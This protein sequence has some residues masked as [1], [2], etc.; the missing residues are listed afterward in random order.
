MRKRRLKKFI[1]WVLLIISSALLI[2]VY[3]TLTAPGIILGD[4]FSHFWASGKLFTQQED[5]YQLDNIL[6]TLQGAGI[7]TTPQSHLGFQTLNPP[8]ALILLAPFGL[9]NYYLARLSWL[10]INIGLVLIVTRQIWK[11]YQPSGNKTWVTLLAALCF[12]PTFSV[13]S[14][15]Q[16]T[17]WVVLGITALLLYT[18]GKV[19]AWCAGAGLGL[20]LL[21]PQLFYLVWPALGLWI[22]IQRR[23]K[24]VLHGAIV[25]LAATLMLFLVNPHVWRQYISAA[26]AYPYEQWATPTIGSYLRYYW[27]GLDK[28]W[29]QYLPAC[30]ALT[31]V[32][33]HSIKHRKHWEWLEQFPAL[34]IVSLLSSP[35]AWTY[36]QVILLPA[37]IAAMVWLSQSST[38]IKIGAWS[39]YLVINLA[40]VLLHT[41]L[42]DFWFLW[43]AP[44]Y[45]IW[46]LF[47]KH[48]PQK[49]T[50]E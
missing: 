36:D 13:L 4:D 6:R 26:Q 21:K 48:V 45:T 7:E 33:A 12:S 43:L 38:P 3:P 41:R 28:F 35:Y 8:W 32:I 40:A 22:I 24:L 42:D 30:F 17:L 14:K 10:I 31:W 1:T 27:L 39:A 46:Y 37:I 29:V 23:W 16:V 50:M 44:A 5:P 47:V 25:L 34:L 19:S 18:Q 9:L 11:L 49:M 20:I 2:I 15:G